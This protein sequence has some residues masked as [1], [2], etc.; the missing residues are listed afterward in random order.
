M[1]PSSVIWP[2]FNGTFRS[3]RT[4]TRLPLRSPSDSRV[5]SDMVCAAMKAGGLEARQPT[6]SVTSTRRFE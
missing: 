3:Q 4:M 1:R 2:F 5:R 6:Y